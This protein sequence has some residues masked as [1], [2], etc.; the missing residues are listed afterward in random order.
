M[1]QCHRPCQRAYPDPYS[2]KRDAELASDFSLADADGGQLA[3]ATGGPAGV[4]VLVVPQD[5]ELSTRCCDR[6]AVPVRQCLEL[7]DELDPDH[8]VQHWSEFG[9]GGRFPAMEAP[10]LLVGDIRAF[11]RRFR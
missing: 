4:R 5:G 11:F 7:L 9:R 10:D 2:L 3:S 1:R 6:A 8:K